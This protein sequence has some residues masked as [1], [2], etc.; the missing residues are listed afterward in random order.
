MLRLKKQYSL[1]TLI[2]KNSN[3]NSSKLY[4]FVSQLIDQKEDNPLPE[5]DDNAILTEQFSKFFPNKIINIQK[6]FQNI[7]PYKT[8][9]DTIPR[10]D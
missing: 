3:E 4:K 9:E 1:F 2:K 6:L 10:F 8:Q 7:P 5:G